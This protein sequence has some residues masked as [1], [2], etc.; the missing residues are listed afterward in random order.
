MNPHH[1]SWIEISRKAFEHNI[2]QF[3]SHLGHSMLLAPVIKSNAYG[4]GMLLI[5][6]LCEQNPSINWMCVASLSE[7]VFL[8][9]HGIQKPL[10]VLSILDD[11]LDAI[12]KYSIKVIAHNLETVI[13]L[14]ELGKR[15]NKK[16]EIHIKIDTGLSRAG[17]L[18][19][20]AFPIIKKISQLSH[21]TIEGIFSHLAQAESIDQSYS[22][23]QIKHFNGLMHTIKNNNI[24]ITH[25][26][27]SCS[28][29]LLI[30]PNLQNFSLARA[31]IG[32]Y[33]LWPS[34]E[35]KT[36][37]HQC[38]SLLN[39]QPIMTWKTKIIHKKTVQENTP[40]GYDLTYKTT[41]ETVLALLPIGYWDGYDRSLS[42][43]GLVKIHA[44]YAPIL[45]RI[46]MNLTIVDITE[47]PNAH[48]GDEVAL[49]GND[50]MISADAIAEKIG[51]INY[52]IVTRINPLLP[53][54]LVS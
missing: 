16:I 35:T 54:I 28:A 22:N 49:L 50:S 4:H 5:A 39:L 40:I 10:I 29:A 21:I 23:E 15:F 17:L 36:N 52:E 34:Q 1:S 12:I 11:T 18:W 2:H 33:G 14:N 26:H 42:N 24:F 51:T 19:H 32:I 3:R 41:R 46:A 31:G 44:S 13:L 27:I 20:E 37:T 47:I 48:V 25:T 45:G 38:Y 9:K 8:R 6:E 7:A 30:H 43:K 53:R